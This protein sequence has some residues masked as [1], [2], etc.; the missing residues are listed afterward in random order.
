MTL[1]IDPV[2]ALALSDATMTAA[3][4]TSANFGWCRGNALDPAPAA[5]SSN[6][7][8]FTRVQFERGLYAPRV[9]RSRRAQTDHS[10]TVWTGLDRELP[11]K[12][13]G[14]GARNAQSSSVWMRDQIR[15]A[16]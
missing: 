8:P 15:G 3:L 5:N 14:R 6:V 4:A 10:D 2:I 13:L 7:T 12:R 16:R 9:R 1:A 11:A